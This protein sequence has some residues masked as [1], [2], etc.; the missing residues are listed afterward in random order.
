MT[1]A[2]AALCFLA[3]V[4]L[5]WPM[6]P[7]T[8]FVV[9]G[10]D[11]AGSANLQHLKIAEKAGVMSIGSPRTG[12]DGSWASLAIPPSTKLWKS[13]QIAFA[14]SA[15]GPVARF[16]DVEVMVKGGSLWLSKG[17]TVYRLAA[18]SQNDLTDLQIVSEAG[19]LSVSVN[20]KAFGQ[21]VSGGKAA[22]PIEVGLDPFKGTFAG[23]AAY[24]RALSVDEQVAN[25]TAV[26]EKSKAL[27]AD[28]LKVKVEGE[29]T[30]ST[31][32]PELERIRPYR[33]ALIAEEYKVV[34]IVSGRNSS[35]KPGMK[36]RIFRYGIKAGEKT[37][38]KDA[39]VGSHAT[40]LIQGFDS[41][42][43]FGREF[44]VDDLEPD[45]TIPLFVD[46]TPID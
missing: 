10:I 40:M 36:I 7:N 1:P 12:G 13:L 5:H 39:K 9:N 19:G 18:A 35:I 33:S 15:D 24:I 42:V 11:N 25:D 21:S 27:F 23:V 28:T 20:G 41:D 45:I 17:S 22:Y 16:G 30:A 44:H 32:V 26:R 38:V 43:K 34:R 37:A 14:Y 2:L 6:V 29:M 3:P 31:P 4:Q 46:V 8:L